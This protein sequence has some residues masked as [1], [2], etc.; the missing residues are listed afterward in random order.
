MR[1][2]LLAGASGIAGLAGVAAVVV[3]WD[4][5]VATLASLD[6]SG[7]PGSPWGWGPA[8]AM[9]PAVA[10]TSGGPHADKPFEGRPDP[11]PAPR[12]AEREVPFWFPDVDDL[13]STRTL[14]GLADFV[15]R[16]KTPADKVGRTLAA[17]I[18]IAM[19]GI[20]VH[21]ENTVRNPPWVKGFR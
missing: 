15:R 10:A 5:G 3:G 21:V 14:E 1:R 19:M 7:A 6:L 13:H 4:A 8:I 18:P 12:P 17:T 11:G 2:P 9:G 16:G 20:G